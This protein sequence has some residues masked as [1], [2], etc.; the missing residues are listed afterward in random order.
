MNYDAKISDME[1]KY[2]TISDYNKFI[3]ELLDAKINAKELVLKDD[4]SG[5]IDNSDLDRNIATIATKA[6]VKVE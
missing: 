4:V 1:G 6:E 3:Y 2:F 5:F